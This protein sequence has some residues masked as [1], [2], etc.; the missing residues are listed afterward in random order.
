M[1]IIPKL[2]MLVSLLES[3]DREIS[4]LLD[5]VLD[6]PEIESVLGVPASPN[7]TYVRTDG[8][9]TYIQTD[10]TYH[11]DMDCDIRIEALTHSDDI[12]PRNGPYTDVSTYMTLNDAN[13]IV[14]VVPGLTSDCTFTIGKHVVPLSTIPITIV[15]NTWR[16]CDG[17]YSEC[18][19]SA[20]EQVEL[21]RNRLYEILHF[22]HSS[23]GESIDVSHKDLYERTAL[24][25]T[26][27]RLRLNVM[28]S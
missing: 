2:D 1:N 8:K 5:I 22:A 27:R 28:H 13:N 21:Y 3:D 11:S 25:L 26:K 12:Q 23:L 14:I 16:Y 7:I 6:I 18:S 4:K 9:L 24:L 20:L 15:G 19:I 17:I 10:C